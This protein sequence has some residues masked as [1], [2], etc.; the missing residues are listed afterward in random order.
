[1]HMQAICNS[2]FFQFDAS[3][4]GVFH[5]FAM[6]SMLFGL[7]RQCQ[8]APQLQFQQQL[9]STTST[10]RC[11]VKVSPALFQE[12]DLTSYSLERARI[13]MIC[14]KS[15]NLPCVCI[16]IDWVVFRVVIAK[17]IHAQTPRSS[18]LAWVAQFLAAV[19]PHIFVRALAICACT[20]NMSE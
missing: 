13:K 15:L 16:T 20:S 9:Q 3:P 7:Q 18:I 10:K 19:Y 2:G 4:T 14:I 12:T 6:T 5:S 17:Y 11:R 1:M 8:G